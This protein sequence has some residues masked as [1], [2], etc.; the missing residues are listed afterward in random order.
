MLLKLHFA[1]HFLFGLTKAEVLMEPKEFRWMFLALVALVRSLM[2]LDRV[3][4]Q[5][6]EQ[7]HV[8]VVWVLRS[9]S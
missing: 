1:G 3:L 7:G 6:L 5:H 2:G 8:A 9:F 4:L